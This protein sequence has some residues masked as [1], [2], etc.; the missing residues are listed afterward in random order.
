MYRRVFGCRCVDLQLCRA[1]VGTRVFLGL[2]RRTR[3]EL[4]LC[5]CRLG[6]VLKC[7]FVRV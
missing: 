5:G 1:G 4:F 7:V 6:C 3:V 2:C